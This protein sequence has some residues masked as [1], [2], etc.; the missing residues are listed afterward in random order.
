MKPGSVIVD[1]AVETGGNCELSKPGETVRASGVTILGPLNLPS[2][3]PQHASVMYSRNVQAL[4]EHLTKEGKVVVAADDVV[5]GPMI[6][7]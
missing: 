6:L 2:Q 3:I 4:L 7:K 1:L 5:A